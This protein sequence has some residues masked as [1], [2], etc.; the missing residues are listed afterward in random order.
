MVY[1]AA[2][3]P[4]KI[5]TRLMHWYYWSIYLKYLY[6][7]LDLHLLTFLIWSTEKHFLNNCEALPSSDYDNYNAWLLDKVCM[8]EEIMLTNT[9]NLESSLPTS[10]Y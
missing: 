1:S 6:I 8:Y 5:N 4:K 10:I 7:T 9:D 2:I 3:D